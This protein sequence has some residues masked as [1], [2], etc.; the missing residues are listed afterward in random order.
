M[1][2]QD[3]LRL[4]SA[5]IDDIALGLTREEA[6]ALNG[7]SDSVWKQWIKRPELC[8]SAGRPHYD[9]DGHDLWQAHIESEVRWYKQCVPAIHF[10]SFLQA[11]AIDSTQ[12]AATEAAK[13]H[14][15]FPIM[16][17]ADFHPIVIKCSKEPCRVCWSSRVNDLLARSHNG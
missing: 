8:N 13:R 7:V 6:C 1:E 16:S 9:E 10:H 3:W 4:F 5:V 12:P 2:D 11:L 17:P 14:P 15:E